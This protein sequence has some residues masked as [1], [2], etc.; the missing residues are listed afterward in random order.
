ML[1][2]QVG[3]EGKCLGDPFPHAAFYLALPEHPVLLQPASQLF[4]CVTISDK[5]TVD[6]TDMALSLSF[7]LCSL[8]PFFSFKH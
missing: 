4:E 7:S 2:C 1:P 8:L 6:D 5:A 3:T